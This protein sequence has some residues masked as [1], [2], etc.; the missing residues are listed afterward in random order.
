MT[1]ECS[2]PATMR[3]LAWLEKLMRSEIAAAIDQQRIYNEQ[4]DK[5]LGVADQIANARSLARMWALGITVSVLSIII[6]ALGHIIS[7]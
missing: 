7:K 1:E 2:P 3:D 5:A 6:A 4:V